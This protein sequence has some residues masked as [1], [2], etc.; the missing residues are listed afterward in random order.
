MNAREK[1]EAAE[2]QYAQTFEKHLDNGVE[3]SSRQVYIDPE[4]EIAPGA[5]ILPGCILRGTTKIGAGCVIGPNTLLENTT[6]GAGSTVNASQCYD[7]ALGENNKIGPFTHVRTGTITGEGV[8]LGAYVET[9]NADFAEGNT[10]SHLTYI[11]DATVGR[12]CN[13]GC[14][15]VTCNYDGE[16]KFHTTIG[17]YV[18]IG[19]NTNLVAPVTVG[20]HAFTAAGSTIGQ[21]VPAGALGIERAKQANVPAW[22][23]K[24]LE[25]YIAKKEKLQADKTDKRNK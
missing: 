3:F 8:H 17:E 19:C 10:V 7:S 12:Y 15:T 6:V 14:G 23:E 16:G 22:G 9:K 1:L 11:G 18:F 20:D 24:K 2:R 13:F 4:V 25:K 21:D 5:V